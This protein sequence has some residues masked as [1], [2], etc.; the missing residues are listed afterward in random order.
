MFRSPRKNCVVTLPTTDILLS[1][2]GHLKL[3]DFGLATL[4]SHNGK[5]RLANT[6]C[7]SPPYVAPEVVAG[8]YDGQFHDRGSTRVAYRPDRVDIWSC[9]VVLF[10]LLVGN[11]PWD[12]P[13]PQSWEFQEY[14]RGK[15][16]S[17]DELWRQL[18]PDTLSL[19]RGIMKVDPSTRWTFQE[20]RRHPWFTRANPYTSAD[21]KLKNALSLATTMLENLK[22][23]LSQ[24]SVF[25][26]LAGTASSDDV[27]M[28]DGDDTDL[29]SSKFASTQPETPLD[30]MLL[31][32]QRPGRGGMGFAATQ[33][34]PVSGLPTPVSASQPVRCLDD[35]DD[36]DDDDYHY[37]SNGRRRRRHHHHHHHSPN[38]RPSSSSSNTNTRGD[39]KSD[40][41]V[42][43]S[44]D[45]DLSE[46]PSM[47]QFSSC[48]SVPL[49]LTQRARRFRDIIP[50]HS[51]TRFVSHF[52][53]KLLLPLLSQ[54]LHRLGVPLTAFPVSAL[55]GNDDTVSRRFKAVDGRKCE[56]QGY[57]VVDRM[58]VSG[59]TIYHQQRQQQ[60]QQQQDHSDQQ[61]QQYPTYD[62]PTRG[63]NQDHDDDADVED[64]FLEVRFVKLKGDPLEWRR[65]FKKV[66]L[67]CREAVY[68]PDDVG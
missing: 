19:L 64:S 55:R 1:A 26:R 33:A 11:T 32:W 44:A 54:S 57:I 2:D 66:V 67:L 10:V 45:Q 7:G 42:F 25:A 9:G 50:S 38:N 31:D 4:Y 46:D 36:D 35:D 15:G 30:D 14:I 5:E 62:D 29:G 8:S 21:G 58:V 34:A 65:F 56:L 39:S 51:L 40:N 17:Q 13:T 63:Q 41:N 53:H 61:Q 27:V 68:V 12:E 28:L 23:D 60:G 59:G 52:P 47:S 24:E 22:I 18:P 43:W 49:S 6:V 37:D 20:V 3:G 48:P 16:R